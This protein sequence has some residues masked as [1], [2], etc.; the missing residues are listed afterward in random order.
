MNCPVWRKKTNSGNLAEEAEFISMQSEREDD[1]SPP[2][3][4]R[5]HDKDCPSEEDEE[6]GTM[7]N[8]EGEIR[9]HSPV[10]DT[11]LKPSSLLDF[12]ED[13]DEKSNSLIDEK[14]TM[15]TPMCID[16][17]E[18]IHDSMDIAKNRECIEEEEPSP[19]TADMCGNE[20]LLLD[21]SDDEEEAETSILDNDEGNEEEVE[22]ESTCILNDNSEYETTGIKQG[23]KREDENECP[24][25]ATNTDMKSNRL[26]SDET[27]ELVEA[28]ITTTKEETERTDNN[29]SRN[30][31]S[32]NNIRNRHHC[33]Q[34]QRWSS[35]WG[36]RPRIYWRYYKRTWE[37]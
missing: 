25:V 23:V 14:S 7:F 34:K 9:K 2:L 6:P 11:C 37:Y 35:T 32:S 20:K 10:V 19:I 29:S 1:I 3:C 24:S 12:D 21:N 16:E 36:I 8:H 30:S 13:D 33:Q 5:E 27:R 28:K 26:Q 15:N 17:R 22:H 18:L 4:T 31:S